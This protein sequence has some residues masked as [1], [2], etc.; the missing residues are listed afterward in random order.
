MNALSLPVLKSV[1]GQD[2]TEEE[3]HGRQCGVERNKGIA[4]TLIYLAWIDPAC[5]SGYYK[6]CVG[7]YAD[8]LPGLFLRIHLGDC[9]SQ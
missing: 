4:L 7:V 1:S 3:H 9:C 6:S 8:Q 2:D 5:P